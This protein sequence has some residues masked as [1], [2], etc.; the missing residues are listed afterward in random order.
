MIGR[1]QEVDEL[2]RLYERNRAEL[3]AVYGRRRVGKTFLADETFSEKFTFRH[4]GFSPVDAEANAMLVNIF[5]T[6]QMW[7]IWL[8]DLSELR[9]VVVPVT[10]SDE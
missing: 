5:V 10:S 8:L 3:M 4:A 6:N 2:R 7:N 1:K 9:Y